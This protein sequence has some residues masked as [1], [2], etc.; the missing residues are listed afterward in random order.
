MIE[1]V[2]ISQI[3]GRICHNL[4]KTETLLWNVNTKSLVRRL[5]LLILFN[6]RLY[7]SLQLLYTFPAL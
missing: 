2:R 4:C 5:A 1:C 6:D 3:S 7:G